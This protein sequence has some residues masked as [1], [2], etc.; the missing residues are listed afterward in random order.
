MEFPESVSM[1][2]RVIIVDSHMCQALKESRCEPGSEGNNPNPEIFEGI[3][4]RHLCDQC[5]TSAGTNREPGPKWTQIPVLWPKV[6]Q[7]NI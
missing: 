1:L 7:N 4:C 2:S 6:G 3:N 5:Y